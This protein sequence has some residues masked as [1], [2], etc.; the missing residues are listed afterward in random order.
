MEGTKYKE[1]SR[2][3]CIWVPKE[4][5]KY[6]EE[7][8]TYYIKIQQNYRASADIYKEKTKH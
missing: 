8:R 4:G 3:Y 5:T 6:K 2:T 1:E 7:S